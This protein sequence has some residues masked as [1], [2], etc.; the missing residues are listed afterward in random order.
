M[1][2]HGGGLINTDANNGDHYCEND[3]FDFRKMRMMVLGKSGERAVGTRQWLRRYRSYDRGFKLF[4]PVI[5]TAHDRLAG[6][7]QLS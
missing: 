1:K 7:Y 4:D 5:H 2:E 3:N 6:R